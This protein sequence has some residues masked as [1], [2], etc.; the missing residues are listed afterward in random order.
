MISTETGVFARSHLKEWRAGMVDYLAKQKEGEVVVDGL[1]R[2]L[3]LLCLVVAFFGFLLGGC[4]Q[5]EE[6]TVKPVVL[7]SVVLCGSVTTFLPLAVAE[8][9]GFFPRADAGS[10]RTG[11]LSRQGS[12]GGHVQR[13]M[14]LCYISRAAGG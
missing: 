3:R 8:K 7:E 13:R 6:P 2:R 11:V 4:K 14:R 1:G 9:Q 10:H 12:T 5:Q